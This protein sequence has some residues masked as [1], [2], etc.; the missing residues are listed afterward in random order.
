MWGTG[1]GGGGELRGA[2]WE[3]CDIY[4]LLYQSLFDLFRARNDLLYWGMCKVTP[5][6]ACS[7]VAADVYRYITG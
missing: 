5:H 3:S 7:S 4:S 1:G 2:M 6:I